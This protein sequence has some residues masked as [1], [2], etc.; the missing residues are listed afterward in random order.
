MQLPTNWIQTTKNHSAL[1]TSPLD[2]FNQQPQQ[3]LK[4]AHLGSGQRNHAWIWDHQLKLGCVEETSTAP[5]SNKAPS[6]NTNRYQ[7]QLCTIRRLLQAKAAMGDGQQ[8]GYVRAQKR[9]HQREEGHI[10]P[11]HRKMQGGHINL[12]QNNWGSCIQIS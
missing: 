4:L 5:A 6:R 12:K 7:V 3:P 10:N 11:W 9:S 8:I 2:C 1:A